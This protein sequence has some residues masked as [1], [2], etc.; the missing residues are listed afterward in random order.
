VIT[1]TVAGTEHPSEFIYQVPPNP[2]GLILIFH[3]GGGSKEDAYTRIEVGFFFKQAVLAGYA[4]AALDSAAHLDPPED[5]KF[6]WDIIESPCNPDIINVVAMIKQLKD[7]NDLGV[8]PPNAPLYA[9]GISNGGSMVSRTAQHIDFAAV[10]TYITNAQQFHDPGA[11]IPP[12]FIMAGANDTTVETTRPCLLHGLAVDQGIDVVFKYNVPQAITPGLFTRIP[13]I[14]CEE[15]VA[16]LE[17]FRQN[18]TVDEAD[19]L[20][21]TP[22]DISSWKPHLP[23]T[24]AQQQMTIRDLLLERYAE[25]AFSSDFIV[26]TLDFFDDHFAPRSPT[27]LPVCE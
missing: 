1:G 15:S 11:K 13:E 4:V 20:V 21:V 6:K 26:E 18:G 7:P 12:V 14:S 9:L 17:S 27:D 25:H 19:M 10:A 23:G 24:T 16:I 2:K 22:A 8:I 5:G 3:G